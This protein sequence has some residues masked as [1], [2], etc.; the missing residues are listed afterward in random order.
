MLC[1]QNWETRLQRL[2]ESPSV[3]QPIHTSNGD[4]G[5]SATVLELGGHVFGS[6]VAVS[7]VAVLGIVLLD[8]SRP[9][10]GLPARCALSRGLWCCSGDP[11]N[12]QFLAG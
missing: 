9:N 11:D 5:H 3:L 10:L 4:I 12:V 7:C 1:S 6:D 8:A 2:R